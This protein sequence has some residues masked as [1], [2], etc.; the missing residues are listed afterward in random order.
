MAYATDGETYVLMLRSRSLPLP[1]LS[2]TEKIKVKK[3]K[4]RQQ[5][6]YLY[7]EL[8]QDPFGMR[9]K[10]AKPLVLSRDSMGLTEYTLCFKVAA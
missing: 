10:T 3:K 4:K 9:G 5:G 7:C 8:L 1:G 6:A 2:R